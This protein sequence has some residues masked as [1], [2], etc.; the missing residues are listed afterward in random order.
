MKCCNGLNA[1]HIH[2]FIPDVTRESF[3]Q[4]RLCQSKRHVTVRGDHRQKHLEMICR[5]EGL[6]RFLS[7]KT[8]KIATAALSNYNKIITRN[9]K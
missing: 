2:T 7:N 4:R 9:S 1:L 6:Y 3:P 8:P 5:S